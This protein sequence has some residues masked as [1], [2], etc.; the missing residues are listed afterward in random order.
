M[1]PYHAACQIWRASGDAYAFKRP[2]VCTPQ[3]ARLVDRITHKFALNHVKLFTPQVAL[4]SKP[5]I[6]IAKAKAKAKDKT[7]GIIDT[8]RSIIDSLSIVMFSAMSSSFCDR[9]IEL[10]TPLPKMEIGVT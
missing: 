8:E 10:F 4:P 1:S 6:V 9:K 3:M 7:G 5:R 2:E